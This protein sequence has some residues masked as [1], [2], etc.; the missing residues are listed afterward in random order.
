MFLRCSGQKM[1]LKITEDNLLV[2]ALAEDE[3]VVR[4]VDGEVVS[5]GKNSQYMVSVIKA[6]L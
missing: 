2:S 4:L 5:V 1:V 3:L 6:F